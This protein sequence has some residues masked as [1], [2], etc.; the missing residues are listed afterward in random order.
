MNSIPKM[1][2][3]LKAALDESDAPTA[4]REAHSIKGSVVTFGAES[5]R[6]IAFRIEQ[7]A[8]QGDLTGAIDLLVGLDR[9]WLRVEGEVQRR[10][11][12]K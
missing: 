7:L 1:I 11:T 12:D 2:T 8:A 4:Q 3:S 9:Q 6:E 10:Q 5:L